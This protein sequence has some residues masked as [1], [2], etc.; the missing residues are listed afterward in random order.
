MKIEGPTLLQPSQPSGAIGVFR[1][2]VIYIDGHSEEVKPTWTVSENAP[3][4]MR[5][6]NTRVELTATPQAQDRQ[7]RLSARYLHPKLKTTFNTSQVIHVEGSVPVTIERI[8]IIGA[9]AIDSNAVNQH[10]FLRVYYSD[11]TYRDDAVSGY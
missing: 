10:Y 8:E 3:V 2:L 4:S 6:M 9:D 7:M 1:C 11:G 5:R